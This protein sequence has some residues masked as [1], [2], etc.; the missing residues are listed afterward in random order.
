MSSLILPVG[1]NREFSHNYLAIAADT[2]SLTIKQ[3]DQFLKQMV[4][5]CFTYRIRDNNWQF[6]GYYTKFFKFQP[7]KN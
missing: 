4:Q 7:L 3:L 6:F 5:N 2:A 1:N